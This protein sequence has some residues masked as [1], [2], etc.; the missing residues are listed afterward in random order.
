MTASVPRGFFFYPDSI[1]VY[2]VTDFI[3]PKGFALRDV[4]GKGKPG[5]LIRDPVGDIPEKYFDIRFVK[6]DIEG[7]PVPDFKKK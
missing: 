2:A 7:L 3:S 4:T 5:E 1:Q 6:L